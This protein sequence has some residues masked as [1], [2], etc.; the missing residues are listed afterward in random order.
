MRYIRINSQIISETINANYF[1]VRFPHG[2]EPFALLF[3][4]RNNLTRSIQLLNL[5]RESLSKQIRLLRGVF[6][7]RLEVLVNGLVG[8]F[9]CLQQIALTDLFAIDDDR[10]AI[11]LG[12]CGGL[13]LCCLLQSHTL[14]LSSGRPWSLWI[15]G[16]LAVPFNASQTIGGEIA[17]VTTNM[18]SMDPPATIRCAICEH[19]LL[20]D[21]NI[22]AEFL[23]IIV[24]SPKLVGGLLN[25]GSFP[26]QRRWVD[27]GVVVPLYMTEWTLRVVGTAFCTSRDK[28]A[29][30]EASG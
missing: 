3:Q 28:P 4:V 9:K 14:F 27:G 17:R 11:G 30:N 6:I 12:V 7:F 25:G 5:V 18:C 22:H 10:C 13:V 24:S 26:R 8:R 16:V 2:C 23:L 21:I 1:N 15:V 20:V 19:V 29:P